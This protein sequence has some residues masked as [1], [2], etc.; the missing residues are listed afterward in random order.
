MKLYPLL[1]LLLSCAALF[2]GCTGKSKK[3]VRTVDTIALASAPDF[4]ADSAVQFVVQQC[5][6]G[7]RVP[8]TKAHLACGN[9][10][11]E[12]F[13]HYGATITEQKAD[14]MAYNGEVLK[15][16]NIIASLNPEQPQRIMLCAHWDCR[17]WAD[18]D[19]DANN[20]R[21]PVMG[22]NDGA[23]GVAV[24]LEIARLLQQK[25]INL[26]VDFFCFD[27]EDYGVAQWD[28]YTDDTS[29]SWCL[30]SQYWAANPHRAGYRARYGVLMDMVGA[31]GATF[32]Q[33]NYS[34]YYAPS[35]TKHI[36][37][38]AHQLGYGQFFPMRKGGYITDDHV[39]VNEVAKIPCV[40]IV[41]NTNH[42]RSNFG[43]TWHT[44]NDTPDNIDSNVLKAVGQTILQL[45]Y[46]ENATL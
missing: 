30:G 38:L 17:P 44:V 39:P 12:R 7:P 10:L 22:A 13:T 36:W 18:N 31:R 34:L 2:T 23:S 41:P 26:G 20:H 15:A 29:K 16:R 27:A 33:E 1:C 3:A 11:V 9:Y 5:A 8:N 43:P 14:L 19:P 4:C 28:D 46:N 24:M 40:D 6:F 32:D 25:P 21:K 37:K 35:E 45:I 42:E